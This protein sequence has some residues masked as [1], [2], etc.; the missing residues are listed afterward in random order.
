VPVKAEELDDPGRLREYQETCR[1][2]TRRGKRWVP[3]AK[4]GA[5]S[6]YYA[7]VYLVVDW[8][9]DGERIRNFYGPNGRLASRPQNMEYFFRPGLTWPLFA[10]APCWYRFGD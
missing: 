4:G 5:Y 6:P 7:D 9:N 2:Q 8:E 10:G 3:F 1:E